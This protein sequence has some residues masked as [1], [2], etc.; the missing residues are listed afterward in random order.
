MPIVDGRIEAIAYWESAAG[1]H[2]IAMRMCVRAGVYRY[3]A[4]ALLAPLGAAGRGSARA[5]RCRPP[6]Y[7][8]YGSYLIAH[9]SVRPYRSMHADRR[10][11]RKYARNGTKRCNKSRVS[12]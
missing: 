12:M 8:M 3:Y 1:M 6:L 5:A 2:G 7:C 4:I 10:S 11:T 9:A